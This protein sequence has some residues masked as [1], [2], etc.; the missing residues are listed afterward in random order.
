MHGHSH[1]KGHLKS[2]R[3]VFLVWHISWMVNKL[4]QCISQAGG[5]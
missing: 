1:E 2:C 4:E 3:R 5:K